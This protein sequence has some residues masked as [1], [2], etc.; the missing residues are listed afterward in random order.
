MRE[1]RLIRQA[2]NA[3]DLD[4]RG[5]GVLTEA[6]SNAFLWTP[7]MAAMAGA[8]PVIAV[9]GD[10]RWASFDSVRRETRTH[11]KA[12]GVAERIHVVDAKEPALL[13]S[14]HLV[15]NLG[16]VRPLD[17]ATV[18]HLPEGAVIA[19]MWEPWEFRPEEIDLAACRRHGIAVLGTNENDPRVRT[20]EFVPVTVARLLL[21]QNIELLG[22]EILLLGGGPF[23]DATRAF[24]DRV[25]ARVQALPA[26]PL[27]GARVS[28]DAIVCLEHMDRQHLLI[29]PGGFLDDETPVEADCVIHVCGPLD[30][31]T[32]RR[33]G[34][35]LVPDEPAPP[36]RMSF[37]T[38]H[39]GPKPVIDLHAAGLKVGEAYLREDRE[40]LG[41][42]A[43]PLR[44]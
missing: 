28:L 19:L 32:V 14:C 22:A 36:G 11:A 24:L 25:G 6:A 10:S 42:L 2:I 40:T 16:F 15:T 9:G 39:A 18:S 5:R 29:G 33:R 7:I 37:T 8:D 31:A 20:F 3:F 23:V 41:E 27:S 26:E 35:R 44:G 12:L 13:A 17:A 38:A 4:L 43:L 34:W 1:Y 21:E 30:V